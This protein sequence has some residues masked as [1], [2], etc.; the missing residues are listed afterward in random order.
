MD[1]VMYDVT[2]IKIENQ[3]DGT[4]DKMIVGM[5]VDDDIVWQ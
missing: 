1:S 3:R 4:I 5:Q 2:F